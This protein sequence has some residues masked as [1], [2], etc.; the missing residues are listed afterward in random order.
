MFL[1]YFLLLLYYIIIIMIIII[2]VPLEWGELVD[3]EELEDVDQ[4]DEHTEPNDLCSA[5]HA[6]ALQTPAWRRA[7]SLGMSNAWGT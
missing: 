5:L 6:A 3:S 1:Y 7:G 2:K 4:V